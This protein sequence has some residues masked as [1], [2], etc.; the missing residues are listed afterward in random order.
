MDQLPALDAASRDMIRTNAPTV[1]Y[2]GMPFG[3]CYTFAWTITSNRQ[4]TL[5]AFTTPEDVESKPVR[6]REPRTY[7]R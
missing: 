6:I 4:A 5:E 2:V 7:P 3:G 1:E